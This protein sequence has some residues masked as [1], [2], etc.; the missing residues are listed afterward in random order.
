MT[1]LIYW[2]DAAFFIFYHFILSFQG[3]FPLYVLTFITSSQN[4][5]ENNDFTFRQKKCIDKNVYLLKMYL[6]KH[7]NCMF[8]PRF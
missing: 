1:S 4:C 6:G 7:T 5:N 8:A 3:L 2:N